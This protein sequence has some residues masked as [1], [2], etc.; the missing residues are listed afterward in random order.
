MRLAE[1]IDRV[2]LTLKQVLLNVVLGSALSSQSIEK[3][4]GEKPDLTMHKR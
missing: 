4:L 2:N 1:E 3:Y